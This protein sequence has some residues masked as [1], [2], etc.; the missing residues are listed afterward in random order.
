M[1]LNWA[2]SRLIYLQSCTPYVQHAV[3]ASHRLE[4][5][6]HFDI[7]VAMDGGLGCGDER[8]QGVGP[9][10]RVHDSGSYGRYR[11]REDPHREWDTYGS[12]FV[13]LLS[14]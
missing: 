2:R 13:T 12:G 6:M 7:V 11:I 4:M 5:V 3:Y 10:G 14:S 1:A 9:S 8:T